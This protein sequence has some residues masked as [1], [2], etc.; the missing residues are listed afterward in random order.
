LYDTEKDQLILNDLFAAD[1]S[2]FSRFSKEYTAASD[3]T[4]NF[5]LDYSKSRITQ[6]IFVTLF[7]LIRKASVEQVHGKVFIGEHLNTS[8]DTQETIRA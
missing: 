5:L 7:N 1:L 4:N 6:P 8:E 2:H 3:P